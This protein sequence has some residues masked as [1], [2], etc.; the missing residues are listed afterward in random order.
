MMTNFKSVVLAAAS[1]ARAEGQ[2][3][4][5]Q[6]LR[7]RWALAFCPDKVKEMQSLV[8]ENAVAAGVMKYGDAEDTA[9]DWTALI[10]F[11]KELLPLILQ[12]LSFFK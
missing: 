7:I 8:T 6:L 5:F 2:I 3:F 10:A 1:Q 11:I 4:G 9:F 12:I